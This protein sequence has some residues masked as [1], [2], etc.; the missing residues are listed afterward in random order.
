MAA[1]AAKGAERSI[2]TT[3]ATTTIWAAAARAISYLELVVSWVW[4]DEMR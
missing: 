1:L 3:M 2:A 4:L